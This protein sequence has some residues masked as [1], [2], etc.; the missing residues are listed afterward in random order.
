MRHSIQ[1]WVRDRSAGA[2]HIELD[3]ALLNHSIGPRFEWRTKQA[4]P[5]PG[6]RAP[7]DLP[8]DKQALRVLGVS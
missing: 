1:A 3:S 6:V 5:S 7:P 8:V 4:G 2:I